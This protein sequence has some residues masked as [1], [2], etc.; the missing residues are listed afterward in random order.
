MNIIAKKNI[1]LTCLLLCSL[2]QMPLFARQELSETLIQHVNFQGENITGK[3]TDNSGDPIIGASIMISGTNKG[4]NSDAHGRFSISA[5]LGDELVVS[6]IGMNTISVK[7][8][9]RREYN[10]TLTESVLLLDEVVA[11]GYATTNSKNLSSSVGT[12]TGEVLNERTTTVSALQGLA[13]KIAG[14]NI[15]TNSGRPDGKTAIKIRGTGSI[16]AS[17]EPLYVIDGFVGGDIN[18]VSPDMIESISIFKDAASSAIYGARGANGVVVITTKKGAKNTSIISYSGSMGIGMLA[19]EVDVADAYESLEI[20]KRAYEYNPNRVGMVNIA[21]HLDPN[22][23]FERK[24]DL[25][26]EDGTPKYNTNWQRECTRLSFSHHHSFTFSGGTEDINLLANVNIKDDEGIML[27]SWRKQLSGYINLGWQ[28]KPWFHLQASITG[29]HSEGNNITDYGATHLNETRLMLESLPF[30]PVRY[31]DGTYTRKGDY[32]GTEEAE[33]PVKMLMER[34]SIEGRQYVFGN[35]AANFKINQYL[36]FIST[37]GAQGTARYRYDWSGNDIYDFSERQQGYAT[38]FHWNSIN[39]SNEDYFRYFRTIEKH[40]IE[41]MLGASWYFNSEDFTQAGAEGFFDNAFEYYNLGIGAVYQRPGSSYNQNTMNSYYTRFNYNYDERYYAT[42][43]MRSDGSSRFGLN[44]KYAFFPSFSGAWRL[45]NEKFF[46]EATGIVNNLKL[47]ASYGF[48]GN[49]GIGNYRTIDRLNE[50]NVVFN[51]ENVPAVVLGNMRNDN[52]TWE[53]SRQ[54]NIG[55][56][57]GFLKDRIEIIADVYEKITTDLLYNKSLPATTGYSSAISNIGSV[58]NRGIEFSITSWNINNRNFKWKTTL[59]YAANRSLVLNINGD[60]I[61]TWG[62]RIEEGGP[63]N[64]F[65]GFKRLGT[66]GIGEEEEA[67]KYNKKP[68]DIKFWDYNN[69]GMKDGEDNVPLGNGMPK[70]EANMSN[71]FFYKNFDFSFDL[72]SMYGHSIQNFGRSMLENR[73]TYSNSYRSALYDA[74]TPE[75]QNTVVAAIRLPMDGY[76]NDADSR[77]IED[78][79]FLRLRMASLGYNFSKET[80]KKLGLAELRLGLTGENLLLFTKYSGFDPETTSFDATFNQGVDMF[81]YP[82]PR[83][84]SFKLSLKF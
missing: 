11:I 5:D 58:R 79:S 75:H 68:G 16:N 60:R 48:V 17:N 31:E 57:V 63:L 54:L 28:V 83:T 37:W 3:I 23:N 10:I 59:N 27:N 56:D 18:L 32:P 15:M 82:K 52:L 21:P 34:K 74:W 77:S 40:Q 19:R 30:M 13:G 43:T 78:A 64:Q 70:F 55:I 26:N 61:A 1:L 12:I 45:S 39:W 66:W 81:Q 36:E 9:S 76:E 49:A 7:V 22:N 69:N 38:R 50:A 44:N 33:N 71:Y 41:A 4:T 14:V 29:G 65:Y 8:D 42:I 51:K 73:V 67:A 24:S 84:F 53:K 62:G 20:F 47:R 6:Y 46:R 25:F 35:F 72:Q 2:L 80:V